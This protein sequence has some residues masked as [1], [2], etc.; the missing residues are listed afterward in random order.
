MAYDISLPTYANQ[1]YNEYLAIQQQRYYGGGFKSGGGSFGGGGAASAQA[2]A[3]TA[4]HLAINFDTIGQ[5]IPVSIG[6]CRL[7]LRPIWAQGINESGDETVSSTQ[8][9]AG[10]LCMPLDAA[11]DGE[12]FSVWDSDTLIM[13]NGSA[14]S[15]VGWS[16]ANA[17]LLAASLSAI[18]FFKGDEAQ[19][20]ASLIVADKGASRTNAFR[21]LRYVIVPEY[22]ISGASGGGGGGLPSL[23]FEFRR[24]KD[25]EEPKEKNPDNGKDTG[26]A[27]E[28]LSGAL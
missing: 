19:L 6:H 5:T 21:G 13:S 22:P 17:A 11:E 27:V 18:Q 26:D 14:L 1:W 28:F 9:F 8:T 15:P 7:Q 12:L 3:P 10:A 23:S 20:P 16:T 24:T 2:P 4:P 25:G